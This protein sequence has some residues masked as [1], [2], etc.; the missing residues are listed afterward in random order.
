MR[1]GGGIGQPHHLRS[2]PWRGHR[3]LSASSQVRSASEFAG[4]NQRHLPNDGD[5]FQSLAAQPHHMFSDRARLVRHAARIPWRVEDHVD[6]RPRR[7]PARSRPHSPPC[8]AF[9]RRRAARRGQRHVDR[10]PRGRPRCRSCRSGRA[11]RCRPGFPGRRRSS[12]PRRCRRS[13]APA[14]PAAAPTA[15]RL[16]PPAFGRRLSLAAASVSFIVAHAKNSCALSSASARRRPR[17]WYCTCAN[18]ARQVEVTPKRAS[19]GS[20][21]GCRRAPRRPRGR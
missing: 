13:A 17:R 8:S 14:P 11:R 21:N 16:S 9:L 19:S 3:R 12:A 18:E 4:C 20:R 2:R 1:V 5:A 6:L 10:S 15:S 7:R